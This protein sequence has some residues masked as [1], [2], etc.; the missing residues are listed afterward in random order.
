MERILR[1]R[2]SLGE[3]LLRR[4][5]RGGGGVSTPMRGSGEMITGNRLRG[6]VEDVEWF[7]DTTD[8]IEGVR[9]RDT[10]AEPGFSIS[11]ISAP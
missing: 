9:G 3:G 2:V 11:S 5:G 1:R 10:S 7:P 6:G 4:R 8:A